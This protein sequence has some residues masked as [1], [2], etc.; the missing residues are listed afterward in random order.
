[1]GNSKRLSARVLCALLIGALL[2]MSAGACGGTRA[3]T[4]ST[5][6]L[7]SPAA[8]G[9]FTRTTSNVIP[10]G[11]ALRGDG[12]A[13]NPNDIDGNGDSDS[14][15]PGGTDGDSDSPTR[16]SYD[17]PDHDDK[18]TYAYGHRPSVGDAR[19]IQG[20][21]ERYYATALTGDGATACSL[22]PTGVARSVP[23]DYGQTGPAYA[24]GKT[25]QVVL[26]KLFR[27]SREQLAEAITVV[28]VRVKGNTAQVVFSS[29]KMPASSILLARPGGSW[30][31]VQLF[32]GQ[33]P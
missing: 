22:L 6:S 1:V 25:C 32:G 3:G 20:V 24:R 30:K 18:A 5:T 9:R 11:Q 10:P 15:S 26:S 16:A 19:A 27:H 28:E 12:D 31:V 17:L 8:E 23:E 7:S 29:Q 2:G 4:R 13:D 14:A 21:V 33:L